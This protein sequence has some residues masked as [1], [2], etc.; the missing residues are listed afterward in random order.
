LKDASTETD[1]T[2]Q[3]VQS[4]LTESEEIETRQ[5]IVQEVAQELISD[6]SEK[7]REMEDESVSL[8]YQLSLIPR[9]Q[10]RVI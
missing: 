3:E 6:M 2:I 1:Y 10:S 7:M 9:I 4:D 8:F 5:L